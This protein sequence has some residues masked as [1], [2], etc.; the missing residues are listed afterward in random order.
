MRKSNKKAVTV[1]T[2]AAFLVL[3]ITLIGADYAEMENV[4]GNA[5]G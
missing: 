2:V 4:L 3:L 1:L 5:D